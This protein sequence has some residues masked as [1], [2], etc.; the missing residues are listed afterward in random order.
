METTARETRRRQLMEV[1]LALFAEKGYHDASISDII[2]RA[3]VARGTFYNYF[4][5]KRE[6]FDKLVEEL[7]DSINAAVFSIRLGS[8][9]DVAEEILE[10]LKGL[11]HVSQASAAG[12]YRRGKEILHDLD[13]IVATKDPAGVM[14]AFV[15]MPQVKGVTVHGSTKSS[16]FLESGV[17]CDLRAVSSDE[18]PF[19]LAYFT[20]SKEHNVAMRSRALK[21]GYTLN[22]YRLAPVEDGKRDPQPLGVEEFNEEEDIYRALG[23][24]FV[25][26]ALRENSGEIEAAELGELPNLIE[27]GNLRGTFHNHTTASDG[28]NTLGEMAEAAREL[29][30]QYLGIADHSKS[31]FQANGLDE[32]R[33][34]AQLDEIDSLNQE[35]GGGFKLF[36]G[37]ECDIL[38][39]GSLDFEDE[40][41]EQ[42]DYVVASVHNSF[43]LPE[44]EMTR[45]I[46]RA[47]ENPNVTMIGHLSGRL[48][49]KR[50][51]YALNVPKVIDA[52]AA[53][54]TI[55]ELN[56]NPW[57]LDMD[58]RWWKRARDKGVLCSI[59]PDA[60]HPRQFQNLAFG[61]RLARKGWLRRQDVLNTR[62]L[63]EVQSFFGK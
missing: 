18:F 49:L 37:T 43:T 5:S 28:K 63:E 31:S 8:V 24:D 22:E 52:A 3:S 23:L 10:M 4:Q 51:P 40:I 2:E 35:L 6:V 25:P 44:D 60:H 15:T 14:E 42:L 58:W 50:E 26:P 55:I 20:G 46:I 56:A 41:L 21:R 32:D 39:D 57:R 53:N 30:L 47:I 48:L 34:L 45:R 62:S 54:D 7:F 16:V 59:N 11:P 1:A 36:A 27:I 9:A 17:Q 19:A 29:G 61:V 12:S 38:K 33:L 13:F